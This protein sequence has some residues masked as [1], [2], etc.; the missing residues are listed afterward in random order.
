[1]CF[2]GKSPKIKEPAPPPSE[3]EGALEGNRE[4][5]R[6]AAAAADSGFQSTVGTSPLGVG[7]PAPTVKKTLG[8]G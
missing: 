8:A 1:M 5:Q 7:E 2:A 4:R 6:A 3:R